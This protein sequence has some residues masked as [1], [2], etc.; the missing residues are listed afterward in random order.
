VQ[1]AKTFRVEFE[2]ESNLRLQGAATLP[3]EWTTYLERERQV[4]LDKIKWMEDFASSLSMAHDAHSTHTTDL[5]YEG[6]G[7]RRRRSITP[8]MWGHNES[9]RGLLPAVS[10]IRPEESDPPFVLPKNE[11][12]LTFALIW[13]NA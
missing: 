4:I 13:C 6:L 2:L 10:P 7:V 1:R 5:P 11:G 12:M 9:T 8:P 3:P